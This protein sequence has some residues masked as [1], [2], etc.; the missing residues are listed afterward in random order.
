VLRDP[1]G[2]PLT[3]RFRAASAALL[4]AIAAVSTAVLVLPSGATSAF[5]AAHANAAARSTMSSRYLLRHLTVKAQQ[6]AAYDRSR[7]KTWTDADHDGCDTRYE[8]LIAEA[9]RKPTVESGCY[10]SGGKWFS[11]YDGVRTTDPSTFDIDHLVPL[12]EVW[13]SGANH[14]TAGTR[15][16]YANDLGYAGTLIA[17][18]AHSNRSK[19]D[20]EPQDWLP[21]RKKYDCTYE[22]TWVAVKWRW[23]LAIDKHEKAFLGTALRRCG[24]PRVAKPARATVHRKGSSGSG[25]TTKQ[26]LD[27]RFSTCAEANAH[28]YGPYYKGRD[29]EYYWYRDADHDG[30]DCEP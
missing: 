10:L 17:V 13:R 22:A 8:V 3:R 14:W 26:H 1:E 24:W 20:R 27:P 4:A 18:T 5:A 19:G 29:P 15:T 11:R 12:A 6:F 21:P 16:R 2:A 28:G 7:F 25:G 30:V 9:V 23:H